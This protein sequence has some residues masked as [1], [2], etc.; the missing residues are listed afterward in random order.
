MNFTT[1]F[2]REKYLSKIETGEDIQN[3]K[4]IIEKNL[5]QDGIYLNKD[6]F[7]RLLNLVKNMIDYEEDITKIIDEF[8]VIFEQD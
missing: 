5:K 1:R 7:D 6:Y 8:N 3:Y 4:N 2:E